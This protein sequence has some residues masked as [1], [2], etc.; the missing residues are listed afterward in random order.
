[1]LLLIYEIAESQRI[2]NQIHLAQVYLNRFSIIQNFNH[3]KSLIWI[4]NFNN[5]RLIIFNAIIC[6]DETML[7]N[8]I[9]LKFYFL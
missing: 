6:V 1:M 2:Q 8:R 7:T 3:S 4:L 5:L 9:I